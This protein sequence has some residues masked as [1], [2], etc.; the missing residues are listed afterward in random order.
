M[1]PLDFS[2]EVGDH[3]RTTDPVDPFILP[4]YVGAAIDYVCA[5]TG[6]PAETPK[7]DLPAAVVAA[8]LLVAGDLYLN[9]EGQQDTPL[10]ENPTV[11]RLLWPYR[12][13]GQA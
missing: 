8:I 5:V 7:N 2:F 6:I 11:M 13:F 10:H 4:V 3:L 9:R 12:R 1:T